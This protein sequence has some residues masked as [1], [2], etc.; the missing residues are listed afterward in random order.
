MCYPIPVTNHTTTPSGHHNTMSPP[1]HT[2]TPCH[3][4]HHHTMT[5][6]TPLFRYILFAMEVHLGHWQS[7]QQICL[8]NSRQVLKLALQQ[9]PYQRSLRRS[10][11]PRLE[12]HLCLVQS[13]AKHNTPWW[14]PLPVIDLY[15]VVDGRCAICLQGFQMS[16]QWVCGL[17]KVCNWRCF[18]FDS[19]IY[20]HMGAECVGIVQKLRQPQIQKALVFQSLSTIL[21]EQENSGFDFEVS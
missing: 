16:I 7:S 1:T 12:R 9:V 21:V 13:Y 5:P 14:C 2:T 3:R 15:W 11:Y 10:K 20:Q 17:L 6:P 18:S 8:S 4:P 19:K